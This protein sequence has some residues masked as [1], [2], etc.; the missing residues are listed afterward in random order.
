MGICHVERS[1]TPRQAKLLFDT[2]DF[3]LALEMTRKR[4][5]EKNKKTQKT[6]KNQSV[7]K[8]LQ[9]CSEARHFSRNT[10]EV[11]IRIPGGHGYLS[12]R[13]KCKRSMSFLTSLREVRNLNLPPKPQKAKR[14]PACARKS[15]KTKV[16]VEPTKKVEKNKKPSKVPKHFLTANKSMTGSTCPRHA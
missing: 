16:R 15:K 13:T 6:K 9:R 8:V 11:K 10:S 5:L 2:R 12:C 3:P 1:E 7:T 4:T 14:F